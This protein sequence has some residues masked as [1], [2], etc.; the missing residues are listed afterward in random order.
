MGFTSSIGLLLPVVWLIIGT[1]TTTL[2]PRNVVTGFSFSTT[3][4]THASRYTHHIRGHIITLHQSSSA[5]STSTTDIP[6]TNI[7]ED[8]EQPHVKQLRSSMM[9]FSRYVLAYRARAT[10]NATTSKR[11]QRH[12]RKQ[13]KNALFHSK[14]LKKDRSI[15]IVPIPV[16][17]DGIDTD[18]S[19]NIGFRRTISELKSYIGE[20]IQLVNYDSSILVSSLTFL[21]LGALMESIIPHYYGQCLHCVTDSSSK[22]A[23]MNSMVGLAVASTLAALFTGMRGSLFWM[24]GS[25]ANYSVRVKLHRNLLRQETSFFDENETG[26]LISRLNSDVNKIG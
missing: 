9:F 4:M 1:C 13:K 22:I 19:E 21:T 26:V 8:D 18:E 20:M 15:E 6:V 14:K 23:L 17:A 7:Y 11:K 12:R 16:D 24:A 5:P 10:N 3:S 25:R 2:R